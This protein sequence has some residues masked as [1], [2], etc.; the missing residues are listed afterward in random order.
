MR[1]FAMSISC[2]CRS[3]IITKQSYLIVQSLVTVHLRCVNFCRF[4]SM[5]L[6]NPR[7]LIHNNQHTLSKFDNNCAHIMPL[8]LGFFNVCLHKTHHVMALLSKFIVT[9]SKMSK[10]DLVLCQDHYFGSY[11]M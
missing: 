1:T 3:I 5:F 9:I 2:K 10:T 11:N 4:C 7:K 6:K 8:L